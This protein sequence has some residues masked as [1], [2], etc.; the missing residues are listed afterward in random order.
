MSK[1]LVECVPNF[2]EGRDPVTIEAIA[3]AIRSV[4]GAKL[5]DVDPGK[6]TNRTVYTFAGDPE[7]VLEAAYQ[8]AKVGAQFIDMRHHHGEHP[9]FG[10]LDVCPII[11]IANCTMDDCVKW[12]HQLSKRFADE[13]GVTVY[14]YGFAA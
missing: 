2:S 13:L 14:N 10:F 4:E 5:L 11:P 1:P 6:S 3:A 8:A 9:R 12:A 7:P